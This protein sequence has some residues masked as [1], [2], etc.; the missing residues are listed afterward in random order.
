MIADSTALRHQLACALADHGPPPLHLRP[1]TPAATRPTSGHIR[2]S[3][4]FSR[5]MTPQVSNPDL[6]A[7]KW[8]RV[9]ASG[10]RCHENVVSRFANLP[11][12]RER[13]P[14]QPCPLSQLIGAL[15]PPQHRVLDG[16]RLS[17]R[18]RTTAF[19]IRASA[20]T[21]PSEASDRFVRLPGLIQPVNRTSGVVAFFPTQPSTR[22][23]PD[24]ADAAHEARDMGRNLYQ[25]VLAVRH[26]DLFRRLKTRGSSESLLLRF[27]PARHVV[28][29]LG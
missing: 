22:A 25:P 23:K 21:R 5:P 7:P 11:A 4:R 29:R 1:L 20:R 2:E 10:A 13:P 12:T 28:P 15:S 14:S 16:R 18:R 9:W 17:A 24:D 6:C 19:S 26:G 8:H 3:F 27:V